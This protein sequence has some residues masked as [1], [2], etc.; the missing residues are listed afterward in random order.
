MEV[1]M[2]LHATLLSLLS[3]GL[4]PG[5]AM[6]QEHHARPAAGR[7]ILLPGMGHLHHPISTKVPMAQRFFDQGLTLDYAFNHD[8]A[9]R[10]FKRAAELDP[11]SPMP[12]WGIALAVGPNYNIDVDAAREKEAYGAIQKARALAAGAPQNE[13]DYVEA[14]AARYS[15]NPKANFHTL[16]V[17]YRNAMHALAARYP[18][19]PDAG[20]LY[21]ESMMDLHPWQLWTAEGQP[22][23]DTE[24]ILRTLRGVLRRFPDHVGA[25][26][27]YIHALEASHHPEQALI[28]AER[29]KTLVPG[30][31]HLVHMPAHIYERTGF[32][33]ESVKANQAAVAADRAYLQL[34]GDKTG[35][36]PMMYYSHNFHFLAEAA[37]MEGNYAIVKSAVDQLTA[38]VTP[39]VKAMPMLEW[40]LPMREFM[41]TRFNRWNE[42]AKLPAPD[43]AFT[44]TTAFWHYARAVAFT[45][46]GD[47][48][49]AGPERQALAD[50]IAKQPA[51]AMFGYTSARTVLG[52]AL[53]IVDARLAA[54]QGDRKGS[55]DHWRHAVATQDG[56]PYDEPPD[57]Y[58]PVRES[59]GAALVS[60]GRYAEAE[61]VF[62]QDLAQNPRNPRSLFGLQEALKGEHQDSDAAW[63]HDEFEQAWKNADTKLSLKDM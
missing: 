12:W 13:R 1:P 48:T 5:L 3:I 41:L 44:L 54:A 10:S 22:T 52:L 2:K 37:S 34:T 58:Y 39:G 43:P 60:D 49:Q 53:D 24:E 28:N 42:V 57:W 36:Y 40:F 17:N 9:V 19:D 31:G 15:N 30:A 4:L 47:M 61:K 55:I 23:Q 62:R 16:A 32:Y 20:T 25:N 7:A 27:F 38:N 11:K 21:A 8:E 46:Q 14:L 50:A 33:A 56:M 35:V 51:D 6:A 26:H 45:A 59:L 18:D 63:V 29:M